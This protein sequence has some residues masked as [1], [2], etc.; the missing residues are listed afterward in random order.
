MFRRRLQCAILLALAAG[1]A[2]AGD[3]RL[4]ILSRAPG[5]GEMTLRLTLRP[6]V[7]DLKA[8]G[9]TLTVRP[10]DADADPKKAPFFLARYR[11]AYYFDVRRLPA[12]PQG[13]YAL[14]VDLNGRPAGAAATGPFDHRPPRVDVAL[15]IDQSYSMRRNDPERLRVAAANRF[16]ELAAAGGRIGNVCVVAFDAESKTLLPLTP[17]SNTGAFPRALGRIS[18]LGQTNMDRA[19]KQAGA[20]LERGGSAARTV[21]LLTDGKNDPRQYENA[22]RAFRGRWPVYAVGLSKEADAKTLKRIARETGGEFFDAP[23]N[24]KLHEIFSRICFAIERRATIRA[25]HLD[26]QPGG[27][28][29]LTVPVDD[30]ITH[31]VFSARARQRGFELV[32]EP[33]E[34]AEPDDRAATGAFRFAAYRNPAV[35]RW[36]AT[37]RTGA[38]QTRA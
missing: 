13:R 14:H 37:V 30:A 35:G 7:P 38:Q 8:D 4:E 25:D 9:F 22:H 36:R 2:R 20:E 12:L 19:L 26:L 34:P 5:S 31:T 28:E 21:L 3:A 18:A 15:V 11:G 32:V 16:V 1:P 29:R 24:K 33:P 10:V 6:D 17:P 23:T 27:A